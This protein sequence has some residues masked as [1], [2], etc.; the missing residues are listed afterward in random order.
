MPMRMLGSL[1]AI[2][3]MDTAIFTTAALAQ[4]SEK[5]PALAERLCPTSA[6]VR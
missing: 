5:G 4:D 6:P 2:A 1:L 3:V